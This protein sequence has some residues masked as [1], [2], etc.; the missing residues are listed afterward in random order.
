MLGMHN[1]PKLRM[2]NSLF[3][4]YSRRD[5]ITMGILALAFVAA[6]ALGRYLFTAPA[7]IQPAAGIALAGLV[8]LGIRMWPAVFIGSLVNVLLGTSP[9]I[10]M[11]GSVL[12]HT[13]HAVVG[14]YILERIGFDPVF[15]RVRDI[16][17]FMFVALFASMIVPSI[18][19][20]GIYL[21]NVLLF[22]DWPFR[23]T[24]VS[25]WAGIMIGDLILSAAIIR[26]FAKTSYVR[27]R[28]EVAELIAAFSV[29][30]ILTYLV[31]WTEASTTTRGVVILLYL[32][33]FVWFSLRLGN[34]F[35]FI[36]FL[37]TSVIA[38]TGT[39]YGNVP[40]EA[41]LARRIITTEFFLATLAAIFFL[42]TAVVEERRRA[43]R[44]LSANLA[45][46]EDLLKK[47]S[48]EDRAK[49]DFIAVFAHEL[50][51]PLAPIVSSIEL[52]KFRFGAHPEI[53]PVLET[54]NDRTKTITRLLDDLLD[55]S[56]ISRQTF[57][58]HPETLDLRDRIG[59]AEMAI[60]P[61]ATIHN[62]SFDVSIP[63]DAVY[64]AADPV[65]VEQIIINL[66]MNAVKY[67]ESGG[68]ISLS[69]VANGDVAE[70]RVRD[71]GAGLAPEMLSRIFV[72][73]AGLGVEQRQKSIKEGLGIGLWLTENLVK[74]HS[75]SIEAKSEGTGR[76]SEFIVRLPLSDK[77]M[78]Y[79]PVSEPEVATG[80]PMRVLVVDDNEAAAKGLGTLLEY[81]GK[82]VA[83]AFG[84]AEAVQKSREFAPD[85]VV[86]DIG[87][88]DLSGYE[89]AQMLREDGYSGKLVALTGYGQEED[90][91]K[92]TEAGFD[93][94][95]TKPVGIADLLA[96]LIGKTA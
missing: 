41:P 56:R 30:G 62:L 31:F 49:S 75:G 71:T 8:L 55:V 92:A 80:G 26:Y 20:L 34:R 90:K 86:L 84:G 3:P 82:N 28:W 48:A 14:A 18:G 1:S 21:N 76:G 78:E 32:M 35:T 7:V 63:R 24:W 68:R 43:A 89:V 15:R 5:L 52:L 83:L 91:K 54:M 95:L 6:S 57:K 85:A 13:L 17:A 22:A 72:P 59:H 38:L 12:G 50:R 53:A 23:S 67:T 9:F 37:F 88:P 46:V 4:E 10:V 64:V 58:L 93:H 77:P 25:W 70:I 69:L 66:L 87:L 51:N 96:V 45:R 79:K 16:F 81:S 29:L 40:S 19:T 2:K 44:H 94:H 60:R 27:K 47:V 61:L 74:A 65:R 39:L 33:P 36:A 42:F 11:A 73:F